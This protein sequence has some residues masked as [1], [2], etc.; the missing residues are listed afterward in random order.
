MY[1]GIVENLV[2]PADL[3]APLIEALVF[4]TS[5]V[6]TFPMEKIK[7]DEFLSYS[8]L[9]GVKAGEDGIFFTLS[10]AKEDRTG[11]SSDFYMLKDGEPR[12]LTSDGRAGWG[13][14]WKK[15]LYFTAKRTEEETKDDEKSTI[16]AL[17]LDGG[18]ASPWL[19]VDGK[20]TKYPNLCMNY[21][22]SS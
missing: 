16:Y 18:E 19:T 14:T 11:Y 12:S 7:L 8:Y 15:K 5:S 9:S 3:S 22:Q 10:R 4:T 6:Y 21:T 13:T 1:Y 17:P 2:V 20:L